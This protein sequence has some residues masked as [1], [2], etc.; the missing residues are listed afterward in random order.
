VLYRGMDRARLDA[1]YNNGAAVRERDAIVADWAGRSARLRSERPQH[2][3]LKYGDA[4]RERVDLFLAAE[5]D[6]PT[7][8]F[9]HGGYWQMNAKELFAF[10]AEGPLAL[11]INVALAGYTLAPEARLDRIV[12]EI[13]RSVL[14]LAGHLGDFGADGSRLYVSGWSAGGHLTAMTMPLP[15]V[16]GGLAISGLYDL[17]PMRLSYINE[18]LGLDEDEAERNSPLLHLPPMAGELIV[19]YGTEELPE[20]QRQS[21]EYAQTWVEEGLPGHLLPVDGANHFTILETLARPDGML[22]Q[23]VARLAAV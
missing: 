9:I 5:P 13:R 2:L 18:K 17:E 3:D 15:A 23:A 20:L 16:R 6:A 19:T 11:G 14:W 7:L 8:V 4:L 10:L 22:A 12:G 21:V 1:A